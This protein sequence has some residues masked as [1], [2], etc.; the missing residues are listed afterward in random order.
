MKKILI[1]ILLFATLFSEKICAQEN[2]TD[3]R[4]KLIF[5]LRAGVN[6]SKV[7]DAKGDNFVADPKCGFAGGA[8]ISIPI[9][10]YLGIQPEFIFSQKGFKATGYVLGLPYKLTRTTTFI[11]VPL[12]LCL[13]ASEFVTVLAGPQFSYLVKQ[14]DAF[15][16]GTTTIEQEQNFEQQDIRKNLFGLSVGTNINLKH[17]VISGR[18]AWDVSKNNADGSSS[19][20]RYKNFNY[21]ITLGYRFFTENIQ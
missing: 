10:T 21:Q 7:Y 20:P 4:Q 17:F 18:S 3:F 11:D 13:K 8:F 9:G 14:V 15:G 16:N 1:P 6:Y 12:F 2:K 19:T 5:G